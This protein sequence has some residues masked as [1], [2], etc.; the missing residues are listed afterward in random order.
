MIHVAPADRGRPIHRPPS[1]GLGSS[2]SDRS[3]YEINGCAPFSL[4]DP[5][6]EVTPTCAPPVSI[7]F[8]GDCRVCI[9]LMQASPG[10]QW[11]WGVKLRGGLPPVRSRARA[12]GQASLSA[13]R[14][15]YQ[16]CML[17][18]ICMQVSPFPPSSLLLPAGP[19]GC[20]RV[21]PAHVPPCA[22]EVPQRC[23]ACQPV[24]HKH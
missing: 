14:P 20:S 16:Y 7:A 12:T 15:I 3:A 4:R 1:S 5:C 23:T 19:S 10:D 6:A 21:P 22:S 11:F 2:G 8:L 13:P 17:T 24:L 18:D 9:F